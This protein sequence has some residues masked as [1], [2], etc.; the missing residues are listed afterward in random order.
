[1]QGGAQIVLILNSEWMSMENNLFLLLLLL[2]FY[3]AEFYLP[4]LKNCHEDTE[5]W[6]T[7]NGHCVVVIVIRNPQ[8]EAQ[9]LKHVKWIQDLEAQ[10]VENALHW[11]LNLVIPIDAS[12]AK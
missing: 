11:N 9:S 8:A 1:M 5:Y 2:F 3:I 4:R 10:Q 6:H 7:D 12:S